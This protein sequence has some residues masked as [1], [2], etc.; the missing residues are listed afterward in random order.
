MARPPL[1]IEFPGA[2][3]HVIS[4]GDRREPIVA[5]VHNRYKL[6]D[7]VAQALSRFNAEFLAKELGLPGLRVSRLIAR[8]GGKRHDPTPCL[9]LGDED[10]GRVG[11]IF[12]LIR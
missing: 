9:R 6:L 4:R 7:M 12:P 5:N 11:F 1:R 10:A 2:V 3:Y 8:V